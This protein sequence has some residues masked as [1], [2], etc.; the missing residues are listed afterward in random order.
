MKKEKAKYE[1]PKLR[2]T[3]L[4]EKDIITTSGDQGSLGWDSDGNVDAG[5][6]T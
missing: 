3:L 1:I 4:E 5:G 6:W 2:I